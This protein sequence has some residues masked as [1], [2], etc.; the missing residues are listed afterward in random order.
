MLAKCAREINGELGGGRVGWGGD[1]RETDKKNA[2]NVK[3]G[4]TGGEEEGSGRSLKRAFDFDRRLGKRRESTAGT[5]LDERRW[6][7]F[8]VKGAT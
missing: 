3:D 4:E 8:E 2:A 5:R 6:S 7:R 1:W